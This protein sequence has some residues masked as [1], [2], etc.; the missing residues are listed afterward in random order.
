MS[1]M[2]IFE[3]KTWK[4]E[5]N[6]STDEI[7][8]VRYMQ[9][10]E[11]AQLASHVME[12]AD[13]DFAKKVQV[14]DIIVAGENFGYGS[15]REQAVLALKYSGIKV[16]VVKSFARIFYRNAFNVG[17]VPL[18]APEAVVSVNDGDILKIDLSK[19]QIIIKNQAERIFEFQPIPDFL[20]TLILQG[21]LMPYLV[22]L[23]NKIKENE[24]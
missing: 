18:M 7:L 22:D 14:N 11:P 4:F 6:I 9:Y 19:G 5:D 15:S 17:L 21:G 3:G 23:L 8:P 1:D 24:N 12:G 16:I 20:Q 10:I 2:C 13:I